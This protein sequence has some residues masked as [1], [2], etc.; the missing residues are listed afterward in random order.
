MNI[1]TIVEK[2]RRKT[3]RL[4]QFKNTFRCVGC[5]ALVLLINS[6]LWYGDFC[7][8]R[9]SNVIEDCH[10]VHICRFWRGRGNMPHTS[11]NR[12]SLRG[13]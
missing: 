3:K 9:F 4:C 1:I 6:L 2:T 7:I 11:F 12:L 5:V 8:I 13:W 10:H